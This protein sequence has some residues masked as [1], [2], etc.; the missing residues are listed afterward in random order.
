MK[1]V[2]F[3]GMSFVKGQRLKVVEETGT[4]YGKFDK[5]AINNSR[6]DLKEVTYEDGRPCGRFRYFHKQYVR[7]VEDADNRICK[8]EQ[9]EKPQEQQTSSLTEK[10]Q[11]RVSL[12]E[13]QLE[14]IMKTIKEPVMVNQPGSVY[15]NALADITKHLTVGVAV[16]KSHSGR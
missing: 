9:K 12:T 6:L 10:Q 1:V 3:T 16:E 2:D 13:K 7:L 5:F 11:Q 15:F 8:S 4:F 14:H